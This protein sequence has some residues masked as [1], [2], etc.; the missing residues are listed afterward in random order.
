M[1][2]LSAEA[3]VWSAYLRSISRLLL[4]GFLLAASARAAKPD[5][6]PA[7]DA[8]S[9]NNDCHKLA[10][11]GVELAEQHQYAEAL[12][13][14]EDAHALVPQEP[15]LVLNIGRMQHKLGRIEDARQR[16]KEFLK[17]A[18]RVEDEENRVRALKWLEE[19]PST[20]PPPPPPPP[21]PLQP[22]PEAKP[23]S[24]ETPSMIKPPESHPPAPEKTA[25]HKK[26]W[27]WGILGGAVGITTALSIGLTVGLS[28][29]NPIPP[30]VT[31]IEPQFPQ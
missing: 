8:C 12:K 5:P 26:W 27:F 3:G 23:P 10:N 9:L 22:P 7:P 29:P 13:M 18:S 17:R 30:G 24:M 16:Y 19:I 4:L 31:V 1:I 6:R 20:P 25:I 28:K 14:F 15:R 2:R 21:L 11:R